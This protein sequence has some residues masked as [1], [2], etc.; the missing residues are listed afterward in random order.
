M[1]NSLQNKQLESIYKDQ[2]FEAV[3]ALLE[4]LIE[5]PDTSLR[6]KD[7]FETLW[8]VAYMEGK[9]SALNDFIN[10]LEKRLC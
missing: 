9:K 4:S 5:K 3:I 10:E 1:T 2:R 7:E 6:G 8:N